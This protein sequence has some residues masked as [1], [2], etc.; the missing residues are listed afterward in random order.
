MLMRMPS[1]ACP[2]LRLQT[3]LLSCR[4]HHC[5]LKSQS[6]GA[7]VISRLRSPK[8]AGRELLGLVCAKGPGDSKGNP[9]VTNRGP[10][11]RD[12]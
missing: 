12:Q 2:D 3:P 4:L 5:S 6:S 10:D 1:I 8:P 9:F 11:E 7:V